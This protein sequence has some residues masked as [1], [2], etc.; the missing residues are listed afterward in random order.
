MCARANERAPFTMQKLFVDGRARMTSAVSRASLL[1]EPREP[2]TLATLAA[3]LVACDHPAPCQV[4]ASVLFGG[5]PIRI[6]WCAACGAMTSDEHAG[7][8]TGSVIAHLL[9]QRH[10]EEVQSLVHGLRQIHGQVAAAGSTMVERGT[11]IDRALREI[12]NGLSELTSGAFVREIDRVN[13]AIAHLSKKA[14]TPAERGPAPTM[15]PTE[16]I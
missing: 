4:S 8:W 1:E 10:F 11:P 14:P 9:S 16:S 3:A 6:T 13:R 12:S 15:P 7:T 5:Q 2:H